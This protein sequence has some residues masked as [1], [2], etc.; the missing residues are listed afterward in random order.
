M[1][2]LYAGSVSRGDLVAEAERVD[3]GVAGLEC[4]EDRF[5]E[6]LADAGLEEGEKL[7][8]VAGVGGAG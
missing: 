2:A 4:F 1:P 5:S 7:E 6:G 3:V 8:L